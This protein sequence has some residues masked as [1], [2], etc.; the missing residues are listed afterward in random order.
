MKRVLANFYTNIIFGNE[1]NNNIGLMHRTR[2]SKSIKHRHSERRC[3]ITTTYTAKYTRYI[4]LKKDR[5]KHLHFPERQIKWLCKT[6][7]LLV[8]LI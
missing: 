8:P 5:A 4:H 1:I 6:E 3:I 2:N 7:N